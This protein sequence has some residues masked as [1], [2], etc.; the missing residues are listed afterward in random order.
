[1]ES[2]LFNRFLIDAVSS[3]PGESVTFIAERIGS[4]D[5]QDLEA[6]QNLKVI[7]IIRLTKLLRLAKLG[8]MLEAVE[9]NFPSISPIIGLFRLLFMMMMAAH[10]NACIF[11]LIGS[12]NPGNSWLSAY[13]F[14]CCDRNV[15]LFTA[16]GYGKDGTPCYDPAKLP[17]QG[18]LYTNAI[19]WSFCTLATVGYGEVAPC[20]EME[21]LYCA[22]AQVVGSA[23]FAY[24]VGSISTVV[25]SSSQQEIKMR[26]YMRL[27]QEY[28]MIRKIP[29]YLA[30][31]VRR[32]CVHRWKRSVFDEEDLLDDFNPKMRREVAKVVY[33]EVEEV[34]LFKACPNEGFATDLM[35]RL[36]PCS[37]QIGE[38]ISEVRET[39]GDMYIV[40]EGE[41]EIFADTPDMDKNQVLATVQR[42]GTLNE[43]AVLCD[44]PCR[45][46]ARAKTACDLYI[47]HRSSLH[48]MI[49]EHTG[50]RETYIDPRCVYLSELPLDE[51]CHSQPLYRVESDPGDEHGSAKDSAAEVAIPIPPTSSQ[52]KSIE[53]IDGS[54]APHPDGAERVSSTGSNEAVHRPS[55]RASGRKG[56]K[57]ALRQ[58]S[59]AEVKYLEQV[60]QKTMD[61]VEQLDSQTQRLRSWQQ[62]QQQQQH[63]TSP[64]ANV[65]AA[66]GAPPGVVVGTGLQ[67]QHTQGP[68]PAAL[69]RAVVASPSQHPTRPLVS[70]ARDPTRTPNPGLAPM[71][72]A[73]TGAGDTVQLLQDLRRSLEPLEKSQ[74]R[75]HGANGLAAHVASPT[76]GEGSDVE[77]S[78]VTLEGIAVACAHSSS[79]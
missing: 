31:K 68:S 44:I 67:R 30:D 40:M 76:D 16:Q 62:Q 50:I 28:L 54:L 11:Y 47:L 43:Y 63:L 55:F 60:Y 66:F 64:R 20:N 22:S 15:P 70:P 46:T 23:M 39:Q 74:R 52:R 34:S 53:I 12:L 14:G 78:T 13:L 58:S 26:E 69:H 77:T 37:A 3:I 75:V 51:V 38:I 6:L 73:R 2:C 18:V 29:K 25:T 21:M 65:D 33:G 45:Y 71:A 41:V 32:Q 56:A 7:R 9:F 48:M 72:R 10:I 36:K 17:G 5:P 1:M 61:L 49:D 57:G 24:I 8:K 42:G 19:Y 35:L 27:L 59:E 4:G 79:P